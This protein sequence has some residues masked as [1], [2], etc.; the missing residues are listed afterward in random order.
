VIVLDGNCSVQTMKD[1][2]LLIISVVILAAVLV[3][4]LV[5]AMGD[6]S[7]SDRADLRRP[8]ETELQQKPQFV[9]LHEQV[10][11]ALYVSAIVYLSPIVK[12]PQSGVLLRI[13]A[14]TM[15]WQSGLDLLAT[16]YFHHAP[17]PLTSEAIEFDATIDFSGVTPTPTPSGIAG[18]YGAIIQPR[19]GL[20][21][22]EVASRDDLML[23]VSLL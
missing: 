6:N 1:R 16:S 14:G 21:W 4:G 5:R 13:V 8:S 9:R 10:D 12:D 17:G 18:Q 2:P 22:G 20:T 3:V 11:D 15:N 23:E 19:P 7:S